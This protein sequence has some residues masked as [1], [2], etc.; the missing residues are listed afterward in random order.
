M[1]FL[2]FAAIL[3]AAPFLGTYWACIPAVLDLW[4]AQEKGI[5]A[6]LILAFQFMPTYIVDT[7]IYAEIKG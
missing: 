3:G 6:I 5:C 1:L 4:L 7:V 2:V